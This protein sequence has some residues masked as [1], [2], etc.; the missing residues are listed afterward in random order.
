MIPELTTSQQRRDWISIRKSKFSDGDEFK[1]RVRTET[2][3]DAE[4]TFVE[5]HYWACILCTCV[6]LDHLG[7]NILNKLY[8]EERAPSVIP[9]FRKIRNQGIISSELFN[10]IELFIREVRDEI[11]YKKG[12]ASVRITIHKFVE[13]QDSD[14]YIQIDQGDL[15]ETDLKA[16]QF[17]SYSVLD[18]YYTISDNWYNFLVKR[19]NA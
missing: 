10:R 6:A 17:V 15:E 2:I 12:N 14:Y 16:F 19:N 3:V 18:L 1:P 13:N 9:K 11:E 8:L 7:F 4:K 5:G